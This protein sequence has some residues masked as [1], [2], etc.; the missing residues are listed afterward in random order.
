MTIQIILSVYGIFR[1]IHTPDE[2]K[3]QQ[4]LKTIQNQ[5]FFIFFF[6][7]EKLKNATTWKNYQRIMLSKKIQPIKV[8]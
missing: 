2:I 8:T 4:V 5:K 6:R 3:S 7:N 1:T